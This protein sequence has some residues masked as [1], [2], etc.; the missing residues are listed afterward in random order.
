MKFNELPR[1]KTK[2]E[3]ETLMSQFSRAPLRSSNFFFFLLSAQ[4]KA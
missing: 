4:M 2:A 3:I 1:G